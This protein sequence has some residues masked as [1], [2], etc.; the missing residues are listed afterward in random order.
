MVR[1]FQPELDLP[2]NV[3]V[4]VLHLEVSFI[5]SFSTFLL[6]TGLGHTLLRPPPLWF[7]LIFIQ[8]TRG[9]IISHVETEVLTDKR[10]V[11][12]YS[13]WF[14]RCENS[15]GHLFFFHFFNRDSGSDSLSNTEGKQRV[16]GGWADLTFLNVIETASQPTVTLTHSSGCL[17]TPGGDPI[18]QL[19]KLEAH[20]V[21]TVKQVQQEEGR[22]CESLLTVDCKRVIYLYT[23]T[24]IH[25][26]VFSIEA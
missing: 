8:V 6:W 11:S 13:V 7:T 9:G 24:G 23:S 10:W 21:N 4:E 5:S 20:K 14:G 12:L 15:W 19:L 1:C 25:S 17:V 22:R 3:K 26:L 2:P 18:D 16:V